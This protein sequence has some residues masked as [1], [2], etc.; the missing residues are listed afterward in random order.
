M[1]SP[2]SPVPAP[3]Q[4]HIPSSSR[5]PADEHLLCAFAASS[6]RQRSGKSISSNISTIRAWHIM[7]NTRYMGGLLL[8]YTIK[9][10]CNMTPD[11]S[12]CPLRP[13][14]SGEMLAMLSNELD[15]EDPEDA[16]VLSCAT[17]ATMGQAR[18]GELLS[19][20]SSKHN[21]SA[22]PSSSDLQPPST[23]SGSCTQIAQD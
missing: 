10:A 14:V 23:A 12:K 3:C 11:S 21:P 9:G 2:N 6:A 19:G 8:R 16:C 22:Q 18:L 1:I 20:S 17:T 13:P 5:L 7:N 4:E 15:H